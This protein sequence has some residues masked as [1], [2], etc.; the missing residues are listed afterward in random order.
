[1][2][3]QMPSPGIILLYSHP[4]SHRFPTSQFLNLCKI[5]WWRSS[6][7]GDHTGGPTCSRVLGPGHRQ[8]NPCSLPIRLAAVQPI[9]QQTQST[10]TPAHR[11]HPMPVRSSDGPD[12]LMGN[13]SRLSQCITFFSD[14]GWPPWPIPSSLSPPNVCVK[15]N[16]PH[17]PWAPAEAP[18]PNNTAHSKSNPWSVVNSPHLLQS[19]HVVGSLLH[20]IFWFPACWG[21]HMPSSEYRWPPTDPQRHFHRFTREP[22]GYH[23]PFTT[24][25]D[26]P[27]WSEM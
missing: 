3:R 25:K 7:T 6:P 20:R 19:C 2:Q 9:L 22:T 12:S 10:P 11:A 24:N 4:C 21:V 23:H 5:C 8:V 27:L 26:R 14:S 13:H 1:M 18:P 15:R 17:H 16:S